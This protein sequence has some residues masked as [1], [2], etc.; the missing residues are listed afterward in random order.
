M[1]FALGGPGALRLD[2]EMAGLG[3]LVEHRQQEP[4]TFASEQ[5]LLTGMPIGGPVAM[6]VQRFDEATLF[7]VEREFL[8]SVASH[9][10]AD[11]RYRIP[12]EFV[13]V[14]GRRLT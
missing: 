1:F 9:R 2:F 12:G 14:A 11:G 4:L 10:T 13:T 5:S 7:A 8:A 3:E 6:A